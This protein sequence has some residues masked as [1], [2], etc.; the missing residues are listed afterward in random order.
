MRLDRILALMLVVVCLVAALGNWLSG[1][2]P[3]RSAGFGSGLQQADVALI[4]VYGIISDTAAGGFG[5]DDAGANNL[6]RAVRRA[7]EDEVK[8]ILLRINSP[9]GTASA[10]QAVYEELM[11]TR[12]ETD[13]K[14][15]ASLGDVAASGGYYVASAA[16]HIVANPATVTG[17]IGVIVRTQNVSS[18]LDKIGVTTSTVQSGQYKD[19][20]SPFR[21]PTADERALV[22]GIVSES[23]QQFLDAIA[24]GRDLS[25]DTL[26]PLADGRIFT[27]SQAVTLELVDSLGNSTDALNKAT[28]LAGIDGEPVVRNYSSTFWPGSLGAFLS[29]TLSE[30]LPGYQNLKTAQW[31]WIPLTLME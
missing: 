25:I 31:N 27:G 5:A 15:V 10:S 12:Q 22:Q 23:Y 2:T 29:T 4:D 28:E 14:I 13:I 7:R 20:L 1:T 30:W 21:D 6:I 18:L 3:S 8:A 16:E 9:G 17:S 19:I 24:A 26:R 11:R